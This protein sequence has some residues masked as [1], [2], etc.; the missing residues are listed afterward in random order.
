MPAPD[1]RDVFAAL[2][3]LV[4]E[5][6]ASAEDIARFR[7]LLRE[8]PEFFKIYRRQIMVATLLPAL[9]F[10]EKHEHDVSVEACDR[11]PM[12]E[13]GTARVQD[14]QAAPRNM[15]RKATVTAAAILVGITMWYGSTHKDM[16]AS[17]LSG[18][19]TDSQSYSPVGVLWRSSDAS[20]LELPAQLPGELRLSRGHVVV[21][22]NS[23]AKLTLFGET[24]LKLRDDMQ[25][26][27]MTG[28]LLA[29]IAPEAVG[30]TVLTPHA[31]IWDLGTQFGVHLKGK[32]IT[33][34]YVFE[35]QIIVEQPNGAFIDNCLAGEGLRIKAD[36]RSV[37]YEAESL[38]KSGMVRLL[39]PNEVRENREYAMS[40]MRKIMS[41]GKLTALVALSTLADDGVW[42]NPAGGAW[43]TAA[44]WQDDAVAGG[45]NATATFGTQV[46]NGDVAVSVGSA[47]TLGNL[48]FGGADNEYRWLLSG[49]TLTLTGDSVPVVEVNNRETV[50]DNNLVTPQGLEKRGAGTLVLTSNN[51]AVVNYAVSAG[52]LVLS[53]NASLTSTRIKLADNAALRVDGISEFWSLE[54]LGIGAPQVTVGGTAK[55]GRWLDTDGTTE[56]AFAGTVS[57]GTLVKQGGNRQVLE[58][59]VDVAAVEVA[60]GTLAVVP[61]DDIVA[62]FGFDEPAEIGRDSG[63]SGVSLTK[64]GESATWYEPQ[65]KSG[66]A[67]RL[68]GTSCLIHDKTEALPMMLP[69]GD[70]AFTIAAWIKPDSDSPERGG[71]AGWGYFDST[72]T[73]AGLRMDSASTVIQAAA[74][75]T[76]VALDTPGEWQHVA[77]TYDPKLTSEKRKIY[78]N[79]VAK[80]RDNP[81]QAFSLSTAFVSVGRGSPNSS[82]AQNQYF[83]GVLDDVV[84]GR[85][86]FS[87]AQIQSLMTDGAAA[88]YTPPSEEDLLPSTTLL[89][90][91]ASG[92]LVDGADQTVNG[93]S[94]AGGV[95]ALAGGATL[96]VEPTENVTLESSVHGLG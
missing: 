57:G 31:R 10:W 16:R 15:W 35:G 72:Y 23:G 51:T 6:Q 12:L 70:A 61:Q 48:I 2:T 69:T 34:V 81:A 7:D 75:H 96:T 47:L 90:V 3:A 38:V 25:I 24:R 59:A 79:G 45:S 32:R 41:M 95:V 44:N 9:S 73:S 26:T 56:H 1:E 36:A 74:G 42:T 87:Q 11:Q 91:G 50:I 80:L 22:L 40:T 63:P 43:E 78:V 8:R 17:G 13:H 64:E 39:K 71:I 67:L 86:A 85:T 93:I 58:G 49:E 20:G 55:V 66:G 89:T 88:F 5:G 62:W 30:F 37:K 94:G 29:D 33:D 14:T 28:M 77:L 21:G 92:R 60:G 18:R 53:N 52:T 19:V 84:L 46:P 4:I 83:K 76:A 54:N 68:N 65:G 82:E 27:L